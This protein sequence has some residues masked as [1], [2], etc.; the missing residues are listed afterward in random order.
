MPSDR[1]IKKA[2]EYAEAIARLLKITD[3]KQ[4]EELKQVARIS[5]EA[6]YR[7]GLAEGAVESTRRE[8]PREE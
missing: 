7:V 3:P 2:E 5:Y 8:T 1:V 4:V 6:G